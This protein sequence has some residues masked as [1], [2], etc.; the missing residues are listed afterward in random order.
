MNRFSWQ[1]GGQQLRLDLPLQG[2]HH[3]HLLLI[4]LKP[5]V[6]DGEHDQVFVLKLQLLETICLAVSVH[7]KHLPY[8]LH[9]QKEKTR[10]DYNCLYTHMNCGIQFP[11]SHWQA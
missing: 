2:D 9:I 11:K 7:H 6:C 5:K 3:V 8:D 4:L 10:F 1:V